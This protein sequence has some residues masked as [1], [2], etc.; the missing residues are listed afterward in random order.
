[1]SVEVNTFSNEQVRDQDL[2]EID[3]MEELPVTTEPDRLGDRLTEEAFADPVH[4]F[5][6]PHG[7]SPESEMDAIIGTALCLDA[8]SPET[9][10]V[11][12]GRSRYAAE[13]AW[14]QERVAWTRQTRRG[15][16]TRTPDA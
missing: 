4:F 6:W 10:W 13:I 3:R 11:G 7:S 15:F 5:F 1:M 9:R 8:D 16:Q 14:W 2:V 12:K